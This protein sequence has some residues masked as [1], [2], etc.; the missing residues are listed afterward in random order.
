MAKAND[1]PQQDKPAFDADGIDPRVLD[2]IDD[3]SAT[4]TTASPEM[5]EHDIDDDG[6]DIFDSDAMTKRAE[7]W[8]NGD[9]K[10][11][12]ELE[13][14]YQLTQ[15]RPFII[16]RKQENKPTKQNPHS[17]MIEKPF[18]QHLDHSHSTMP[19]IMRYY[20]EGMRIAFHY[21]PAHN[22][23]D[24]EEILAE[25]RD[26]CNSRDREIRAIRKEIMEELGMTAKVEANRKRAR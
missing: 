16:W 12:L 20:A 5:A 25:I 3:F 23:K 4:T 8:E 10:V 17:K 2:Q 26:Y 24:R 1:V 6:I 18:V 11:K 21:I 13:K 9:F 22:D 19:H 15:G 7:Q 14:Q